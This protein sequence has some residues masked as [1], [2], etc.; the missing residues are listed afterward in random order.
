MRIDQDMD[1]YIKIVDTDYEYWY[2]K[3]K[4]NQYTYLMNKKPKTT[5]L[6]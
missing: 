1:Y 4:L 5:E 2:N 6:P 3:L